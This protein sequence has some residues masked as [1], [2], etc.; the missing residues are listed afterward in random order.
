MP[1][2]KGI[3]PRLPPE[4]TDIIIDLVSDDSVSLRSCSLT[5]SSWLP[6]T[7]VHLFKNVS[8]S[9]RNAEAF[10]KLITITPEIGSYV[11]E[12]HVYHQH[13]VYQSSPVWL[14]TNILR[15]LSKYLQQVRKIV[16]AGEGTYTPTSLIQLPSIEILEIRDCGIDSLDDLLSLMVGLPRLRSIISRGT[17]Y[18]PS[19]KPPKRQDEAPP[20]LRVLEFV[21]SFM[22]PGIYMDWLIA[23]SMCTHLESLTAVPVAMQHIP[24]LGRV[25]QACS[26]TLR[27]IRISVEEIDGESSGVWSSQFTLQDCTELQVLE[28]DSPALSSVDLLPLEI[29][30]DWIGKLLGQV[31]SPK[32]REVTLGISQLDERILQDTVWERFV[33]LLSEESLS[34]L[35]RV[36]VHTI[37][38]DGRADW[39]G[40]VLTRVKSDLA[41]LEGRGALALEHFSSPGEYWQRPSRSLY[42]S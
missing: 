7:R 33:K 11:R 10:E 2:A 12:I 3:L 38:M 21:Q 19:H 17:D 26:S 27:H 24:H 42:H 30:Y 35:R 13:G 28:M 22:T 32:I 39:I 15:P 8:V 1:P 37:A 40:R 23:Q 16:L 9:V 29:S 25:V 6:R 41:D 20:S 34:S 31:R 36:T 4:L 5:C 18:G 14:D